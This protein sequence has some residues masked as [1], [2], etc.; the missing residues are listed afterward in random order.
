MGCLGLV[1]R[2][3]GFREDGLVQGS[4]DLNG[5]ELRRG[6]MLSPHPKVPSC[7]RVPGYGFLILTRLPSSWEVLENRWYFASRV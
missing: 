4:W 1:P 3:E 2:S 5:T 7:F 6:L